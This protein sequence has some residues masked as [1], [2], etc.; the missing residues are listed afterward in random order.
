MPDLQAI[1]GGKDP[2]ELAQRFEAFKAAVDVEW[3]STMAGETRLAHDWSRPSDGVGHLGR[4]I[5]KTT[6]TEVVA[7]FVADARVQ[8]ALSADTLASVQSQVAQYRS[9]Q[10]DLIK[11]I[12]TTSPLASGLVPFDLEAPMSKWAAA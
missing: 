9:L 10:A 7:N 3:K 2:V 11:D 5:D 8:K 1:V 4:L 12:T 6:S